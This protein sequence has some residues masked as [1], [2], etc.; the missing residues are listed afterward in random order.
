MSIFDILLKINRLASLYLNTCLISF[1]STF[2]LSDSRV[3]NKLFN[4]RPFND[5]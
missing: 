1:D 2:N 5:H 3:M 4:L